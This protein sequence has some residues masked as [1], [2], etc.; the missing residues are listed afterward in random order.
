MLAWP[1]H[2][3]SRTIA[4]FSFS[5]L[6]PIPA[7]IDTLA[8]AHLASVRSDKGETQDGVI[9]IDKHGNYLSTALR[10]N[11]GIVPLFSQWHPFECKYV[12]RQVPPTSYLTTFGCRFTRCRH[13]SHAD[14][15]LGWDETRYG[16]PPEPGIW[17]VHHLEDAHHLS[18]AP[19]W[20]GSVEQKAFWKDIGHW[21]R[22]I[23]AARQ[24]PPLEICTAHSR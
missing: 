15:I 23:D 18:I 4:T 7:F 20:F 1:L 21:L 14:N 2:L 16:R 5:S 11:D 13:F 8:S 19:L 12:C 9:D 17:H 24:S 10:A 22:S 3:S 6:R